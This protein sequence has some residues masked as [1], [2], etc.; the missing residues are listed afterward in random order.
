MDMPNS[1]PKTG[2]DTHR[3]HLNLTLFDQIQHRLQPAGFYMEF[4]VW[5]R[6]T[7][8]SKTWTVPHVHRYPNFEMRMMHHW[9]V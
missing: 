1:I 2:P 9:H 7:M 5:R 3:T 4:I 6:M 8:R